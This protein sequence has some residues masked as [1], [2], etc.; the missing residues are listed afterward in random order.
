MIAALP[1][2]IVALPAVELSLKC[3]PSKKSLPLL[4]MIA[5]PALELSKKNV[6]L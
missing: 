6:P 5:L 3:K 2:V 1:P 4:V